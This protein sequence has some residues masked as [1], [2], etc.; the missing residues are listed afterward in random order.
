MPS[1][2]TSFPWVAF[3]PFLPSKLGYFVLGAAQSPLFSTCVRPSLGR[4]LLEFS[5]GLGT[6]EA[7][8]S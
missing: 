6:R 8:D 4:S 5:G 3:I 7:F 2:R 1:A